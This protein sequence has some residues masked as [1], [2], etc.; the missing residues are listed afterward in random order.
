MEWTVSKKWRIQKISE[1]SL[2][3]VKQEGQAFNLNKCDLSFTFDVGISL[4]SFPAEIELIVFG[5]IWLASTSSLANF[6]MSYTFLV[7][8]LQDEYAGQSII[9][10]HVLFNLTGRSRVARP[11]LAGRLARRLETSI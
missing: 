10:Q 2:V 7:L 6:D 11:T 4:P 1:M 5:N 8:R 9:D 3:T